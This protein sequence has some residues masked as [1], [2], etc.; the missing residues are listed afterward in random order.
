M[1]TKMY[2]KTALW[3]DSLKKDQRGVTSIEY[4]VIA[5]AIA[6]VVGLVFSSTGTDSLAGKLQTKLNSILN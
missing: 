2:V 5:A 1:L 6:T 3:L 4:A